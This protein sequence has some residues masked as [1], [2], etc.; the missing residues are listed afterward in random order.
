[1]KKSLLKSKQ[2]IKLPAV[3]RSIELRYQNDYE[4]Y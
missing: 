3:D 2:S 4:N 1:M